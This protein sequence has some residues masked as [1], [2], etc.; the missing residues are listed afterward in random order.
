MM[1]YMSLQRYSPLYGDIS[2]QG[3]RLNG[4]PQVSIVDCTIKWT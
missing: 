1:K 3:D 4:A 2:T